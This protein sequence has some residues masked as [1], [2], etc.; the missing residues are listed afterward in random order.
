MS[1]ND[2]II[3]TKSKGTTL[4]FDNALDNVANENRPKYGEIGDVQASRPH[5]PEFIF[6]E[7]MVTCSFKKFSLPKI[8]YRTS[9]SVNVGSIN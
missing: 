5:S 6:D 4:L 2:T 1:Q 3:A 9:K 7:K 8:L